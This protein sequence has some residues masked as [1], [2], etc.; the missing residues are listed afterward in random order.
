LKTIRKTIVGMMKRLRIEMS[1]RPRE[2]ALEE[3]SSV[4]IIVVAKTL[5]P[6]RKK[7]TEGASIP[8]PY[9][10]LITGRVRTS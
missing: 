3:E 5:L 10:N 1:L 2:A 7:E 6:F 9:G 4:V 8:P